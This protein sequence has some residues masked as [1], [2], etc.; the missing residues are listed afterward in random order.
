MNGKNETEISIHDLFQISREVIFNL[1]RN[2]K[3][4]GISGVVGIV[5][6]LFYYSKSETIYSAT[7]SFALEDDQSRGG[8][9]G[10][11]GLAS[12]FGIDL[13][14]SAGGIFSS[15]NLIELFK[16]RSMTERA[17][18]KKVEYNGSQ[19]T[20]ADI[21]LEFK[22]IKEA[23]KKNNV[24]LDF[25]V[26]SLDTNTTSSIAKDSVLGLIYKD[27]VKNFLTVSQKDKKVSIITVNVRSTNEKF[28]KL[29]TDN[30]AREVSQYYVDTKTKRTKE[31]ISILQRQTDS[32]RAELN[33]S[34]IGVAAETENTFNMNSAL[35]VKKSG[36]QK[37]QFD[38]QANTLILTE[39]VKNLELTKVT[40]R[41]ET[42]LIQVIDKPKYPLDKE[43]IGPL[44]ASFYGAVIM[45]VLMSLYLVAKVLYQNK[46]NK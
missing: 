30:L 14:G 6:G 37:K 2:W 28:A 45:G 17:L 20:L 18:L 36:T 1:L 46:Q 42:P 24:N 23:W 10:A 15:A 35:F 3:L 31:N 21:Y 27:I 5:L 25:S 9:S 11:M 33:Q 44:R 13:G 16:S 39:L 41:K 38:V 26:D 22:E 40:L 43:E 32:V 12:Q 7:L 4:L 8:L 19:K 29:F 34:I